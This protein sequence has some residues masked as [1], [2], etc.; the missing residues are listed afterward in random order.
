MLLS[1]VSLSFIPLHSK[2]VRTDGSITRACLV[3]QTSHRVTTRNW[4]KPLLPQHCIDTEGNSEWRAIWRWGQGASPLRKAPIFIP[5]ASESLL[6]FHIKALTS[7]SI[8]SQGW[9]RYCPLPGVSPSVRGG[10]YTRCVLGSLSK[11]CIPEIRT[12]LYSSVILPWG[13]WCPAGV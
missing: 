3:H 9:V 6:C 8:A 1:R 11:P 13:F 5:S 10:L 7:S 2:Y 4:R 12:G